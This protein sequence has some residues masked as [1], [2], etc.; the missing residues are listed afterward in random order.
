[1]KTQEVLNYFSY[2]LG[3]VE[4]RVGVHRPPSS[5]GFRVREHPA[6]FWEVQGEMSIGSMGLLLLNC[7]IPILFR[8]YPYTSAIMSM[9]RKNNNIW[10]FFLLFLN[11]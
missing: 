1:M 6:L 8:N 2:L 11:M 7:G 3:H 4:K 5:R 10:N 9:S